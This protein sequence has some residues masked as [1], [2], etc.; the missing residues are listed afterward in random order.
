MP[1]CDL[2]LYEALLK[3]NRSEDENME[4]LFLVGNSLGAY[5][6]RYDLEP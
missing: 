3:A 2:E 5:L 1:H 4:R 6:D